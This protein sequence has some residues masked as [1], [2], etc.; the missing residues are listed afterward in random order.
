MPIELERRMNE[1]DAIEQVEN[2][3][4]A[5]A[6]TEILC[7]VSRAERVHPSWPDDTI[8]QVAI[9]AEEAG[10]AVRAAN[11]VVHKGGNFAR[12]TLRIEL[13]QTG[14]MVVRCLKNLE[15]LEVL[16]NLEVMP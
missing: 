8:H 13:V 2:K 12:L 15:N 4:V 14:A 11:D 5:E 1:L 16:K 3:A 9:M 7:E 10:E 6:L